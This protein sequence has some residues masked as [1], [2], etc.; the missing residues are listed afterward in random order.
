M[1]KFKE[2]IKELRKQFGLNQTQFA[3]RICV[4][5]NIVANWES[6]KSEPSLDDLIRISKNFDIGYEELLK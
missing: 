2:N 6:D 4:S 1:T 5:R 3:K